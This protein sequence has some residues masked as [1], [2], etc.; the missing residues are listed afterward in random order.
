MN[1]L[2]VVIRLTMLLRI[3][4]EKIMND[5]VD[6]SERDLAIASMLERF[7]DRGGLSERALD[8][9]AQVRTQGQSFRPF[10]SQ[11]I[12]ALLELAGAHCPRTGGGNAE[13]DPLRLLLSHVLLS[14]QTELLS[15]A[16]R[17]LLNPGMA[18]ESASEILHP[19][20]VRNRMAHNPGWY[21]RNAMARIYAIG[22]VPAIAQ[23]LR[24]GFI[25]D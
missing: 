14:I 7:L 3:N 6:E 10:S 12:L 16:G 2:H 1:F 13:A 11:A 19:E 9:W 5:Q 23:G 24:P 18:M 21:S 20:L 22:F 17:I 25:C 15:R 8:E 4:D